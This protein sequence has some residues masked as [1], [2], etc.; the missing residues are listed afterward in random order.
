MCKL[1]WTTHKFNIKPFGLYSVCEWF[2]SVYTS[3]KI[4][5]N[6]TNTYNISNIDFKQEKSR[7]KTIYEPRHDKTNKV[8]VCPEKIQIRLPVWSEP[9]LCP[10]WIAKDLGFLHA[11]SKD[12]DQTG[13]MPRLIWVF[14]GRTLTLLALSCRG[15][16]NLCSRNQM[17]TYRIPIRETASIDNL[18]FKV[19][20]LTN[21]LIRILDKF[22]I[23]LCVFFPF[24]VTW[25]NHNL[26][27]ENE[28]CHEKMSHLETKPTKWHVRPAKTQISLGIRPVWLESSLCTQW[29]A[30][31]TSILQLDS[32]HSDQTGR[33]P[34][35]I[36]VF[37]GRT[38]HFVG[39]VIS[40]G[41][42]LGIKR[43][44]T[45]KMLIRLRG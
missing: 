25:Y 18:D 12:S 24:S 27:T 2:V 15:S 5:K 43:Q 17:Q 31:D 42:N 7:V 32:K 8:S 6:K 33:M 34:R 30:K 41:S 1:W 36:W 38:C 19:N 4:H 35:L 3:I 37:A 20:I 26:S 40:T 39:F 9:S 23:F 11:A 10:Q 21:E 29:E 14:A 28:K 16:Y 13:R 44:Q 45:T 22:V